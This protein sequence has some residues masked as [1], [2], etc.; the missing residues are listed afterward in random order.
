MHADRLR[1]FLVEARRLTTQE[2]Y[3]QRTMSA[4]RGV[5]INGDLR[6]VIGLDRPIELSEVEKDVR[7]KAA[8]PDVFR[9]RCS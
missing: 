4:V 1:D 8:I 7:F 6:V 5:A 9:C 2:V 3:S